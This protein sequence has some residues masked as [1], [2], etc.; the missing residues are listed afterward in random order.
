M[1][2]LNLSYFEKTQIAFLLDYELKNRQNELLRLYRKYGY[3]EWIKDKKKE[4]KTL[5]K[6]IDKIIDSRK[7]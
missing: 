7:S 2:K 5:Y 4:C 6:I 3:F 1:D